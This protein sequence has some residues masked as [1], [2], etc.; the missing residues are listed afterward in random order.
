[1]SKIIPLLKENLSKNTLLVNMAKGILEDGK[2]I[3]EFIEEEINHH[4]ICSLKGA[5]F[6]AEM[7]HDL[8]TLLTMGFKERN[9]L[10]KIEKTFLNT[11]LFLDYTIDIRGVELLSA[12]KNIYAILLGY[13]DAKHNAANT[14][15]MFLTKTFKELKIIL[16]ELGG[17]AETVDLSCGIGDFALTSL[18]DLSRNRT[19][20]LLIGKGFYNH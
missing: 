8:P 2:T 1:I 12:L 7:I 11:N 5:S 16:K 15:F 9:Q 19:L 13:M 3:V 14:R 4:N 10:D 6:S 18:N 20:G 17:K